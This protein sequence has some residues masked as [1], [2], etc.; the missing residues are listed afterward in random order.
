MQAR[1]RFEILSTKTTKKGVDALYRVSSPDL[2][3]FIKDFDVNNYATREEMVEAIINAIESASVT[4]KEV[5]VGF[6]NGVP[7]DFEDFLYA[8]SGGSYSLIAGMQGGVNNNGNGNNNG[9]NGNHYGNGGNNGND[10]NNGNHY[11]DENGNG[12][13]PTEPPMID[14]DDFVDVPFDDVEEET[15]GSKGLAYALNADGKTYCVIGIGSCKDVEIIIPGKYNRK[16]VTKIGKDAF[17]D[18]TQIKS[19]IIPDCVQEIEP[20]V[21]RR[22]YE[23]NLGIRIVE[24]NLFL[25]IV[26]QWRYVGRHL[27]VEQSFFL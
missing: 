25:W 26:V 21:A 19:V 1:I 14:G 20:F 3:A 27:S 8:Y 13:K 9:N 4:E 6:Q 22:P 24:R 5:T 11:G 16:P 10:D 12:N 18:N 23:Q 7:V 15:N 2:T 17:R